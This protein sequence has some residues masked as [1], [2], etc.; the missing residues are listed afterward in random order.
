MVVEETAE[1]V[2]RDLVETKEIGVKRS[3]S[4][5]RQVKMAEGESCQVRRMKREQIIVDRD[6][7]TIVIKTHLA[8]PADRWIKK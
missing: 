8:L 3:K 1:I 5:K 7:E 6:E 2:V 4:K